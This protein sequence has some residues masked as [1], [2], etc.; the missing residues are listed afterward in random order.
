MLRGEVLR[1]L[2][3]EQMVVGRVHDELRDVRRRPHA[4]ERG[5]AA[6]ALLRPV[7]AARVELHDA[8]GIRQAAVADAVV[9][10]IE[11]DDVDAGDEGVEHVFLARAAARHQVE[12]ALDR[13]LRPAVLVAVAVRR[14]DDDRLRLARPDS[15]RALSGVEAPARTASTLSSRRPRQSATP[16]ARTRVVS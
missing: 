15:R 4:F 13:R 8:V 1:A 10:R 7:H 9:L 16:T 3:D 12:R 6:G 11:L 5:D 2:A 14:G